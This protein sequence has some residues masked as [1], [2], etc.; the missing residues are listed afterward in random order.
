MLLQIL[1]APP[2]P[3]SNSCDSLYDSLETAYHGPTVHDLGGH[4]PQ[5]RLRLVECLPRVRAHHEGQTPGGRRVHA[6]C[7]V[8]SEV[9]YMSLT[10]AHHHHH[11]HHYHHY[12]HYHHHYLSLTRDGGVH[13]A[14]A[15]ASSLKSSN[16]LILRNP[17]CK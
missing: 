14:A 9:K 2:V 13:K 7:A 6:A 12:H 16:L 3:C 8:K 17:N 11:H 10:L 4:G 1:T 5:H 15:L